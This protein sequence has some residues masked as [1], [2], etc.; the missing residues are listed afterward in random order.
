M[1][2]MKLC[3][4]VFLPVLLLCFAFFLNR[5][6]PLPKP[7]YVAQVT[8]PGARG[9]DVRTESEATIKSLQIDP[10]AMPNPTVRILDK[11]IVIEPHAL[12][13]NGEQAAELPPNTQVIKLIERNGTV[14][15]LADAVKIYQFTR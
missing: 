3:V 2:W 14:E 12:V 4:F 1:K 15:V 9:V 10:F 5:K 6:P 8:L 11:L 13:V 7:M